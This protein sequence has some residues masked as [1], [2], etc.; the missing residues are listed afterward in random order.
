MNRSSKYN[1]YLPQSTD[2]ISVSDFNYNFGLIDENLITASQ[3]WTN[4]QKSTARTN[5]GLGDAATKSVV[6]NLNQ[7]SS[8]AVLDARQG[9]AISDALDERIVG[10]RKRIAFTGSSSQQSIQ[11]DLVSGSW[12]LSLQ[13]TGLGRTWV[14]I[15]YVGSDGT[16]SV[17][18]LNTATGITVTTGTNKLYA[19][20]TYTNDSY[21][22]M[23]D[24]LLRNGNAH[25]TFHE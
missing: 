4:T 8:G 6:N 18:Q 11:I 25:P 20:F 14:G 1:F 19:K 2:P 22:N 21:L 16:T 17:E 12:I 24:I 7:T 9:K 5:I 13:I 23:V 10:S 3:S 15:V